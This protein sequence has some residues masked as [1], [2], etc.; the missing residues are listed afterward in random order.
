MLAKTAIVV[1]ALSRVFT[2]NG[3]ELADPGPQLSVEQVK[4]IYSGSFPEL[5]NSTVSEPVTKGKKLVYAFER[6]AGAKG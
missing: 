4:E 3:T 5:L 1:V 2:Y 6:T